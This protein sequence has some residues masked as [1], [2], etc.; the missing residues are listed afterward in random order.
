MGCL[1][2]RS[3]WD[4]PYPGIKPA[5]PALQVDSLTCELMGK[6]SSMTHQ[7]RLWYR[8]LLKL[9]FY[10]QLLHFTL[11]FLQLLI[12][13]VP[14]IK[15]SITEIPSQDLLRRE[16]NLEEHF[17]TAFW[18]CGQDAKSWIKWSFALQVDSLPTELWGKPSTISVNSPY[19]FLVV[20]LSPTSTA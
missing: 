3:P 6:T 1:A 12:S 10:C 4:R 17:S 8:F 11:F 16:P 7:P 15:N 5:S 18:S 9:S 19:I 13:R 14:S 20:S 2:M